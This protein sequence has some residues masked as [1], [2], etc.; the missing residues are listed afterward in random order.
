MPPCGSTSRHLP[1]V[2]VW[3]LRVS[4]MGEPARQCQ[5]E[6]CAHTARQLRLVQQVAQEMRRQFAAGHDTFEAIAYLT[7]AVYAE[8]KA[9]ELGTRVALAERAIRALVKGQ[10]ATAEVNAWQQFV[11][12]SETEDAA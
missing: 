8:S 7:R 6:D 4:Q 2:V 3:V 1:A 11:K 9:D 5:R 12:Q 10:K